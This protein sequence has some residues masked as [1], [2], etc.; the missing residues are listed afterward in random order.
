MT[1]VSFQAVPLL[2]YF[3]SQ[4][5]NIDNNAKEYVWYIYNSVYIVT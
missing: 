5:Y 1:A 2:E 3:L 4:Q